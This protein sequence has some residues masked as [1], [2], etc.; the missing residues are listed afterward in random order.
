MGRSRSS[1]SL[2]ACQGG[3]VDGGC[4]VTGVD[5]EVSVEI[6]APPDLVW[7][8]LADLSLTP[9]INRETLRTVWLTPS[10]GWAV[11]SVFRATNRIG[12]REWSVDC[13]VTV[14]DRPGELG[15]TVLDPQNPSSTWWYRLELGVGGG[16]QV[17]QG[18]RHGPNLSGLRRAVEAE[19]ARS[20]EIVA[21][22]VAMLTANMEYTLGRVAELATGESI[23]P[24]GQSA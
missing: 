8:L 16:T 19:P 10:T 7:D 5:A 24:S 4:D 6:A 3:D 22:R 13:H 12:E 18:F 20:A 2:G 1:V 21:G 23:G 15:W 9:V 14:A 17:T 11:G